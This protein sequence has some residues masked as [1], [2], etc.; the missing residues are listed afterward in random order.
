[1][2]HSWDGLTSQGDAPQALLTMDGGCTQLRVQSFINYI[3]NPVCGQSSGQPRCLLYLRQLHHV[4]LRY[5][6]LTEPSLPQHARLVT[7]LL[8]AATN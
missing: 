7:K 2:S 3:A 6:Y 5:R 8:A 4:E 1:M